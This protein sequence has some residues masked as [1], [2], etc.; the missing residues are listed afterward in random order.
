LQGKIQLLE[1]FTTE[2]LICYGVPENEAALISASLINADL[3]GV[4]SHGVQRLPSYLKR[5]EEGQMAASANPRFIREGGAT[6]LLDGD[7]G[8]GQVSAAAAVEKVI[9]LAREFGLGMVGVR[10]S[11]HFGTASF[12]T[13]QICENRLI[14][15][16]ISNAPPAMAPFGAKKPLLGTNPL[17]VAVPSRKQ[18]IILDM[19][20]TVAARGKIRVAA[21][22]GKDIP[23][24]WALDADGNPTTDPHEALRGSLIGIGGPKGSGLALMIELLTG[25]LTGG[26]WG[27]Q[28]K[29]VTDLS[30]PCGT[31]FTIGAID[32]F[33]FID[34]DQW[35]ERVSEVID[36]W[37]ALPSVFGGAVMLPGEIEL[38][39]MK[40]NTNGLEVSEGLLADLNK[41]GGPYNLSLN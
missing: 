27:E 9:H 12:F 26:A 16:A 7:N 25:I 14:G 1:E 3:K 23:Q 40:E 18:P 22:T 30:G 8:F 29:Q 36:S 21:K 15:W 41:L 2:L 28:L 31:C 6:A 24:G 19:A 4:T 37:Q 13:N 17:S 5:L 35:E 32:P 20:T 11:N 34:E 10:N 33:K 39:K 38:T